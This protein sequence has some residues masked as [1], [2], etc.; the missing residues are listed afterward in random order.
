M[1][2]ATTRLPPPTRRGWRCKYN[3]TMA[4]KRIVIAGGSG[5]IGRVLTADFLA[6]GF[7]VAVLTRSPRERAGGVREVAW[8]GRYPGEWAQW[9]NGA[10]AVFNLAGRN[11]NCPHT[12]ENLSAIV[13]SRVGSVNALAAAVAGAATPPRTWVQA[14][15]TGFYGDTGDRVCDETAPVG[16]DALAQVCRQ[17]EAAFQA[18]RVPQTRKVALRIG[19]VLGRDGGA[20]P[21][22]SRLVRLFLGG[23]AGSGGQFISWVHIADLVRMFATAAG[24][25]KL[26]GTFN[27]VAP[28]AVT[29]AEF[30]RGLR[31]ALRRP[32]SPPAPEFAVRL[33]ARFMG[34]EPSLVLAGSRC[35]PARFL[36]GGFQ[37][38]FPTL[39]AA[40]EDLCQS[41]GPKS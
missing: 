30:M 16:S 4:Q 19:F 7:E 10:Q 17:W 18:A 21:V 15:A 12:A 31:R 6:R 20:L 38:Q 41:N 36:S 27:A 32:W 5:F 28:V 37:F 34:G 22:L 13:A 11:I 8:D 9:L 35:L 25:E 14:S 1:V 29:N 40:L 2:F 3:F 24:D 26:S 23:A 39:P 33:G